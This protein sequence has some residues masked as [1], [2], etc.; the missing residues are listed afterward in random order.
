ME[1]NIDKRGD[2]AFDFSTICLQTAKKIEETS[3]LTK[4][5]L[6]RSFHGNDLL[7]AYRIRGIIEGRFSRRFGQDL[8]QDAIRSLG[9]RLS[10][11]DDAHCL[12]SRII[13][14]PSQTNFRDPG[15]PFLL[16]QKHGSASHSAQTPAAG[17]VFVS[18][19]G[20]TGLEPVT[21]PV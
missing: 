6:L 15:S 2:E 19:V 21:F 9:S 10:V 20:D 14:L 16:L 12:W 7:E 13:R 1:P 4:Q 18:S 17:Q 11:T 5:E 3:E 8:I